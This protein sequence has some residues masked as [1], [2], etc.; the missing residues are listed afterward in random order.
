MN[1][2]TTNQEA[3]SNVNRTKNLFTLLTVRYLEIMHADVIQ[4]RF[5]I[6]ERIQEIE[7]WTESFCLTKHMYEWPQAINVKVFSFGYKE[8]FYEFLRNHKVSPYM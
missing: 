1:N 5:Q 3:R 8:F 6:Q 7:F 2:F 4:A